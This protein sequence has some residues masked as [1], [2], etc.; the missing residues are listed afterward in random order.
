MVREEAALGRLYFPWHYGLDAGGLSTVGSAT[1][2]LRAGEHMGWE[3]GMWVWIPVS[4]P[5]FPQRQQPSPA[6]G[7]HGPVFFPF[8]AATAKPRSASGSAGR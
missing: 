8:P 3:L 4:V 1:E 5:Q 2:E 6:H 7:E